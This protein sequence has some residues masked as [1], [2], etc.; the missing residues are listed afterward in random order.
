M[1]FIYIKKNSSFKLYIFPVITNN[2]LGQSS[3]HGY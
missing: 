2:M 3:R 1:F